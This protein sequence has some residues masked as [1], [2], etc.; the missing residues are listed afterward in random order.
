MNTNPIDSS[1]DMK[2]QSYMTYVGEI[3][4]VII[5]YT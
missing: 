5:V 4:T 3:C 1:L 2:L